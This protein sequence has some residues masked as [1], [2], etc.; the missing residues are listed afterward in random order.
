MIIQEVWSD[1]DAHDRQITDMWDEADN[2]LV[3]KQY[4]WK[5]L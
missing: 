5:K 4:Q 2:D 1:A 3:Q